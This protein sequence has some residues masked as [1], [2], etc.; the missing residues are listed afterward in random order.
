MKRTFA[1]IGIAVSMVLTAV[2]CTKD[3][4]TS[5]ERS[6]STTRLTVSASL[7]DYAEATKGSIEKNIRVKWAAGDVV[8]VYDDAKCLGTLTA[9]LEDANDR[10]AVLSGIITSSSATKLTLVA[11]SAGLTPSVN[12]QGT[13]LTSGI[14]FD[15]STQSLAKDQAPY[16]VYTVIDN[17]TEQTVSN[18]K[19]SFSFATSVINVNCTALK[20]G[21]AVSKVTLSEVNTVMTIT[22][23]A[24]ATPAITYDTKG[25]ITREGAEGAALG[26]ASAEGVLIFSVAVLDQTETAGRKIHVSQSGWPSSA[27]FSTAALTKGTSYNT[28]CQLSG[29]YKTIGGHSGVRLWDGG[30]YW[31]TCNIGAESPSEN[32]YYYMWG[33]TQAYEYRDLEGTDNDGFYK[34]GTN[35]K[36]DASGFAWTNYTEFGNYDSSNTN[37]Y[38]FNKYTA[39]K[40]GGDHKSKLEPIDDAATIEWGS[41]WRMPTGGENGEFQKLQ[42]NCD[43]TW[44]A[45][46]PQGY[47]VI[48]KGEYAGISLFFPAAGYG[49]GK[50][51]YNAG[52][53]GRYW[54]STL[55]SSG[56]YDAYGLYFYNTS[57]TPQDRYYRYLGF[58]VRPVSD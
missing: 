22:P 28:V 55:P 37:T 8:Y 17:P 33:S 43:W 34:A 45:T 15:L 39:D 2:S 44:K 58:P 3:L 29:P 24:D 50:D 27:S 57:V 54:S 18:I 42:D 1:V 46:A 12:T 19:T 35:T 38:G 6:S 51:L 20:E 4:N 5:V 21:T 40:S 41:P 14:T 52:E 48:G 7:P 23:K 16:V 53:F 9:V 11:A 10:Y 31:A 13:S 56:P 26:I 47:L 49:Y 30:P 25:T 36:I 32:G